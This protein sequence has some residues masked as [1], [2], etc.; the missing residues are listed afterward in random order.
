MRRILLV[1]LSFSLAGCSWFSWLPWVDRD[2][3]KKQQK[4]M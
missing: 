1:L 4:P 3:Q 2:E